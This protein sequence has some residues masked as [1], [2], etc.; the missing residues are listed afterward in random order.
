MAR[1][2]RRPL[3]QQ[4]DTCS[5][6]ARKPLAITGS[7]DA[8]CRRLPRRPPAK[9]R[10]GSLGDGQRM[11]WALW[12]WAMTQARSPA[13]PS[14]SGLSPRLRIRWCRS[15]SAFATPFSV[16]PPSPS[17]RPLR[18]KAPRR[19]ARPPVPPTSG[20][21]CCIGGWSPATTENWA[22]ALSS[23]R[24]WIRLDATS[25]ASCWPRQSWRLTPSPT[26]PRSAAAG[27]SPSRLPRS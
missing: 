14:S 3:G 15:G 17:Y 18:A 8:S 26:G 4:S 6:P 2:A 1:T 7:D 9:P 20:A 23:I 25:N 16:T 12:L 13:H 5:S 19:P 10:P 21:G 11:P 22:V 27:C 24:V